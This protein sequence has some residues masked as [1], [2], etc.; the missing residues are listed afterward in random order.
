MCSLILSE[1]GWEDRV[2]KNRSK[3]RALG[4]TIFQGQRRRV[5]VSHRNRLCSVGKIGYEPLE[6][7]ATDAKRVWQPVEQTYC[8]Q[9]CQKRHFDSIKLEARQIC[10]QPCKEDCNAK[11]KCLSTVINMSTSST[12]KTRGPMPTQM[13]LQQKSPDMGEVACTSGTMVKLRRSP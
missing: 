13:V 10:C 11:Q 12:Q 4:S 2:K 8:D 1:T 3:D 6:H 9:L 5:Y 7:S